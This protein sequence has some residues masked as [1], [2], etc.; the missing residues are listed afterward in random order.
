MAD[1]LRMRS[2]V[3]NALVWRVLQEA[4]AELTAASGR[5]ELDILDVGGGTGGIAVPLAE[6]GHRVTV[7]DTSPDSLA[8]L[9]RRAA[10]AGVTARVRGVQGDAANV[11]DLFTDHVRP[12]GRRADDSADDR[13]DLVVCHSVLEIVD[14]PA[15]VL[16]GVARSLRPRGLA[17]IVTANAVAA[18]LHRAI[19]GRFDE[20]LHVLRDPL[21]RYGNTDP[22]PRRFGLSD[23]R[24]L[25]E[26]AGLTV[27]ATHGARV[28]A[29]VVP[30]GSLDIDPQAA[31]TLVELE[32]EAADVPALRDVASALHLIARR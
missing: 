22:M 7:V 26:A 32:L 27:V 31:A 9:E 20:A 11:P 6:L 4:I 8:A 21:G 28:F 19:A 15:A 13:F 16:A 29:D 12:A 23:V 25:V 14:D 30:S 24:S 3:R 10:E 5:D 17:S 1:R 18:A 2:S